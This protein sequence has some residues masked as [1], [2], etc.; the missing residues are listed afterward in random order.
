[1]NID[2]PRVDEHFI[3]TQISNGYYKNATELIRDAVR[4][5]REANETRRL[6][7][8]LALDAGQKDIDAGRTQKYSPELFEEIRATARKQLAEGRMPSPD[9]TG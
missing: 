2:L 7:L 5:L 1:M 9:V 3:N 6:T 4:R 8:L